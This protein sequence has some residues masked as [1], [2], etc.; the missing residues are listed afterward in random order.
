MLIHSG[1][2]AFY[3]TANIGGATGVTG[4]IIANTRVESN[5]ESL[6]MTQESF[7][8]KTVKENGSKINMGVKSIHQYLYFFFHE[9][10][11]L[12]MN[13]RKFVVHNQLFGI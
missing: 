11:T 5:W 9:N 13:V 12:I 3:S 4:I 1:F 8:T 7:N 2:K 10:A 6:F